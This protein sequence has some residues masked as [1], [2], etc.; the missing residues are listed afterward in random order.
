MSLST[1][2]PLFWTDLLQ[3][4]LNQCPSSYPSAMSSAHARWGP[5][6][7]AYTENLYLG[8]AQKL[9]NMSD[10]GNLGNFA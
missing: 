1:L 5:H 7:K 10:T 8:Y 2:L 3:L 9:E 4:H 6:F